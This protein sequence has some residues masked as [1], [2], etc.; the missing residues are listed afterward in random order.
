MLSHF[1]YSFIRRSCH[2]RLGRYV[3]K[4]RIGINP[5]GY[6]YQVPDPPSTTGTAKNG[7]VGGG[8][9]A[10]PDNLVIG[11]LHTEMCATGPARVRR[12]VE[13]MRGLLRHTGALT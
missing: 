9:H 5:S 8:S 12:G 13:L 3:A 10:R 2:S 6:P 1:Y 11:I 4:T 7:F